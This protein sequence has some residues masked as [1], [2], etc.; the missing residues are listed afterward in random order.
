MRHQSTVFWSGR[1]ATLI[2]VVTALLTWGISSALA[3]PGEAT[4]VSAHTSKYG[5]A[6]FG[7][8]GKVLYVFG[9]DKGSRSHCY[10]ACASAWPPLLST[11]APLAGSG[12]NSKLLGTTKRTDGSVQVTYDG[13]PLYYYLADTPTKIMCQHA[14]MH[15]GLWLIVKPNGQPNMAKGMTHM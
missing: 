11:G 10:G 12:V 4:R 3:A 13:R 8:S 9:P 5:M 6:L 7:P 1:A 15:G 2:V 14:N